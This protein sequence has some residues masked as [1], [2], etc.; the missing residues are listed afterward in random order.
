MYSQKKFT[1]QKSTLIPAL[2]ELARELNEA[3]Y[4]RYH[5]EQIFVASL[6]E[7]HRV[8]TITEVAS[9]DSNSGTEIRT[10]TFAH[11]E[12][13]VIPS[14]EEVINVE[15]DRQMGVTRVT[16][17]RAYDADRTAKERA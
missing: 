2:A 14:D 8:S 3:F 9:K 17:S 4:K 12:D 10:Q 7:T 1:S 6:S 5:E 16:T 11:A 15:Y 13:V